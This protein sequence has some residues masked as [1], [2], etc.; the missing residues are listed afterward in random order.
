MHRAARGSLSAL[1]LIGLLVPS[2]PT[3]VCAEAELDQFEEKCVT[4]AAERAVKA[5][6]S[7]RS[8][9]LKELEAAF[10]GKV[11]NA[12]TDD[13]YA[14]WFDLVAGK[15]EEWRRDAASPQ[16]A[17]LFDRVVQRLELGPVPTVKREEFRKYARR[18][19]R[20]GNPPADGRGADPHEDADKAF[21]VLDRNGDGELDRNE[22]TAGLKDEKLRADADG[23]GRISKDEYRAY[24]ARRVTVRVDA[25][26]AKTGD[27]ARG[28][29]GKPTGK[30]DR[31]DKPAGGLP[32]WFATLDTDKDGQ[33]SLFEWR[34]GGRPTAVFQEMDLNGDG[35][36]TK[37]EYLR[38]VRLKEIEAAQ[39]KRE[40]ERP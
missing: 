23:N 10:P 9:W 11:V 1:S 28:P 18:V 34:K 37:D 30:A 26:A 25:I 8:L 5:A 19:L 39:K 4:R 20:E 33:V 15:N 35:L 29:D 31:G 40:E 38:Y 12:V 3:A 7:D 6:K 24:F 17:E 22:L 2:A 32:D 16:L 21:R 27:T 14:T 13:E 36:L